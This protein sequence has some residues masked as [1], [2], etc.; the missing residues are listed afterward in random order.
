MS[1]WVKTRLIIVWGRASG[2]V[3]S[4]WEYH[5]GKESLWLGYVVVGGR[6]WLCLGGRE[7]LVM[8][9]WEGEPLRAGLV[10]LWWEG[11]PLRAGLVY[12]VV[13]GRTSGLVMSWWEGEPGYVVVGGR[14]WLCLGGRESL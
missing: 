2:L 13:G 4:W 5:G 6:V 14:A 11:E 9:W 1:W 8:S 3:M 7:S 10:M 12:V